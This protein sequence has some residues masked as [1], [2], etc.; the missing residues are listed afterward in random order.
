M[1][2]A[3]EMTNA[4]LVAVVTELEKQLGQSPGPAGDRQ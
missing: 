2:A 3:D 4:V 1:A